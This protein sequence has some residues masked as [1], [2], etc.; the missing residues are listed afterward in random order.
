MDPRSHLHNEG[1]IQHIGTCKCP[2]TTEFTVAIL[3]WV[4]PLLGRFML[5]WQ[6][7]PRMPHIM[8]R[9]NKST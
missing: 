9:T 6:L 5:G 3:D 4:R 7:H 2:R 1:R 8:Y